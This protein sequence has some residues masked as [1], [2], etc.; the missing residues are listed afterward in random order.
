MRAKAFEK[1][2]PSEKSKEQNRPI[3][4]TEKFQTRINNCKKKKL[5]EKK[6]GVLKLEKEQRKKRGFIAFLK[7]PELRI[8]ILNG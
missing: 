2:K 3:K 5:N 6:N 1:A 7:V 8:K 4:T